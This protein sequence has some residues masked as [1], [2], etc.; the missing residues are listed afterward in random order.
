MESEWNKF[1]LASYTM[2]VHYSK[3]L[4][5][6][7]KRTHT[8]VLLTEHAF[9]FFSLMYVYMHIYTH[10]LCAVIVITLCLAKPFQKQLWV[11]L[12][13]TESPTVLALYQINLSDVNGIQENPNPGM[14]FSFLLKE[15]FPD[16]PCFGCNHYSPNLTNCRLMYL[17]N[18]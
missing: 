14:A 15:P 8:D 9:A 13:L 6:N 18:P 1:E 2:S 11:I 17:F 4:C 3:T 16:W 10:T 7:K 12:T 5:S